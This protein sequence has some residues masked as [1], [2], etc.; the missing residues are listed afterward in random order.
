MPGIRNPLYKCPACRKVEKIT[1]KKSGGFDSDII[2]MQYAP[3]SGKWLECSK[4][5]TRTILMPWGKKP[6]EAWIIKP[7]QQELI[8]QE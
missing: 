7:I 8:C 6:H 4:C 1:P 2:K 3:I 5:G